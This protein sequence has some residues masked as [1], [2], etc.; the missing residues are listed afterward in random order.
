M[1]LKYSNLQFSSHTTIP[2]ISRH[3]SFVCKCWD[4]SRHVTGQMPD[5]ERRDDRLRRCISRVSGPR[6][7]LRQTSHHCRAGWSDLSMILDKNI[8]NICYKYILKYLQKKD[9]ILDIAKDYSN[10]C[11]IMI[12]EGV[13][14]PTGTWCPKSKVTI[15]IF[16]NFLMKEVI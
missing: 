10:W 5:D 11:Y 8:E 7:R 13:T 14:K 4:P 3:D 6:R 9:R 12:E 16:N 1:I 2:A 15:L